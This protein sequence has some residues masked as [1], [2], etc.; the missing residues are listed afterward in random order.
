MSIDNLK[1]ANS[2]SELVQF[3]RR[4]R[5]RADWHEPTCSGVECMLLSGEFDN[6]YCDDS[7][8][9][10]LLCNRHEEDYIAINMATLL[11]WVTDAYDKTSADHDNNEFK[12]EK[13]IELA[14]SGAGRPRRYP[15]SSMNDGDSFAFPAK[16]VKS[17]RSA[18]SHFSKRHGGTFIIRRIN[19]DQY[20]CWRKEHKNEDK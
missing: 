18:A 12:V 14:P 1:Y 5:L 11:S 13:N 4:H 9:G 10:L 16:I 3:H 8:A 20:R 7:E 6:A 17:V 15:F 19:R 2:P